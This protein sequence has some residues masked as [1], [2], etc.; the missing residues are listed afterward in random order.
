MKEEQKSKSRKK[1][2]TLKNWRIGPC[3]MSVSW[4]RQVKL[5]IV[6]SSAEQQT[7]IRETR[8]WSL[9]SPGTPRSGS[10]EPIRWTVHPNQP[11][12]LSSTPTSRR[13]STWTSPVWASLPALALSKVSQ[14]R[15][16]QSPTGNSCVTSP[17]QFWWAR[18]C[19]SSVSI[20]S[21]SHLSPS[22]SLKN[23]PCSLSS[24]ESALAHSISI[25]TT[26]A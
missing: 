12:L 22:L 16:S 25:S 9:P 15:A 5:S 1:C 2:L 17:L 13:A 8:V 18:C 4:P 6:L 21:I 23:K 19:S 20:H 14:L 10:R 11:S 26:V 7:T 24:S 3:L